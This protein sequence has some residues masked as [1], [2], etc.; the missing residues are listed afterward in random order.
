MK[1]N[2]IAIKLDVDFA[3]ADFEF[4]RRLN[5]GDIAGDD[6]GKRACESR[7]YHAAASATR[8]STPLTAMTGAVRRTIN[9]GC[10]ARSRGRS[11]GEDSAILCTRS[12]MW[13]DAH[14]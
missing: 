3:E 12:H 6:G 1:E 9:R 11:A 13:N 5:T 14:Y 10:R 2:E 7:T 4:L 8:M